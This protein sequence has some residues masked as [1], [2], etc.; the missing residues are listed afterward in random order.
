MFTR[1]PWQQNPHKQ[2]P[3]IQHTPPLHRF[4]RSLHLLNRAAINR[5][6]AG[7][8][9]GS[10]VTQVRNKIR[11]ET[12]HKQKQR[13]ERGKKKNSLFLTKK[14]HTLLAT[15]LQNTLTAQ[16][17]RKR[18]WERESKAG[19]HTTGQPEKDTPNVR[20]QKK[21]SKRPQTNKETTGD[22][23]SGETETPGHPVPCPH[24]CEGCY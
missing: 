2:I 22:G 11:T 23:P 18:P 6:T 10:P 19:A 21:R 7:E 15:V 1:L 16:I 20:E 9:A 13:K 24:T 17:N 12:N 5:N 4:A 3:R 14:S 8:C